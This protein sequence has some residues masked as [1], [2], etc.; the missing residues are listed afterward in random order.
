MKS[1]TPSFEMLL[2]KVVDLD[3]AARYAAEAKRAGR[4]VAFTNGCFDIIHVGHVWSLAQARTQGDLL[5][6][7]LNSDASARSLKGPQRPI[8]DEKSR[9]TVLA[10]MEMVDFI[11]IFSETTADNLLRAIQ[12]DVYVKGAD[13]ASKP[14][15]E[16]P[17]VAE[18][19]GRIHLVPLLPASSTTDIV[20]EV[21]K[22]GAH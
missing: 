19:G 7:G 18:Y 22:R 15:P 1:L 8:V 20:K 13:Y 6:V 17:T 14:L 16:A 4:I 21:R 9:A 11:V 10:A 2:R 5:I 3:T 12:P